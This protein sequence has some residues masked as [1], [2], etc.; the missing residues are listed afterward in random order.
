MGTLSGC[1][2]IVRVPGGETVADLPAHSD[3]VTSVALH[4]DDQVVATASLD[5]TI[6]LWKPEGDSFQELLTLGSPSGGVVA[7]RFSPKGDKL[8]FLVKNEAVVRIWH[9][10]RLT[11]RLDRLKIGW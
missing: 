3:E 7:I 11:H 6:K 9:L 2:R 5:R 1:V 8:A 4:P 10:D